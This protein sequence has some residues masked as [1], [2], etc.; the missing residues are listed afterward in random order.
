METVFLSALLLPEARTREGHAA[1]A[2]AV[3]LLGIEVVSAR[4]ATVALQVPLARFPAVFGLEPERAPAR[5]GPGDTHIPPGFAAMQLHVPD[6]L[7]EWV[8]A[9]GVEPP[10]VRLARGVY[11]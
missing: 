9:I 3:A 8:E 10:G 5:R 4:S 1:F 6:A 11:H 7:V 2:A